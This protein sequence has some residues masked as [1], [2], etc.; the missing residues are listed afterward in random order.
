MFS[1]K[2]R[3]NREQAEAIAVRALQFLADDAERLN[4]FLTTTGL[5]SDTLR[6][7]ATSER[8]LVSVMDYLTGDD[9]LIVQFCEQAQI[10]PQDAAACAQIL[11]R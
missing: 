6:Q 4:L 5:Q 9:A 7:A 8:F 11:S 1:T 3:L 10:D 2:P